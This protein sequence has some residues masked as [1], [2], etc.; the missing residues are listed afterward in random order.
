MKTDLQIAR[1][2]KIQPV[3]KIAKALGI[4]EGEYEL[5]GNFMAKLDLAVRDRL[6]KRPNGKYI[7]ITA[8]TPTPL[9]EGKTTTTIGLGMALNLLGKQAI[10]AIRQPSMGPTFGIKGG[11]AGGGYAQVIPMEQFNLHLT[12]DIHA[13]SAAHNLIAAMLDNH[14]AKG[15]ALKIDLA[16]IT[17]PRVVDISDRSLRKITI[18]DNNG[19]AE[20]GVERKTK[21]DIAVAS[22]LMAILA[23]ASD[24]SDLR[25]RIAKI[26]LAYDTKGTPIT[27]E[28]IKAAGAAT[29]L[30]KEAIKPTLVQ[31]LTNT[32]AIVHAGPFANIAHGNSSIIADQIGLKLA[33]YLVTESGFGADIG[34]E[35]FMDIKCRYSGLTPDAVV[36]VATVRGIKY[37]SGKFEVIP[38]KPLPADLTK[39]D[40]PSLAKGVVNLEKQ[41]ENAR[42]FGIPVVVAVNRFSTDT[43]KEIKYLITESRKVGAFAA[44]ESTVFKDG[45]KGGLALANAVVK[46]TKQKTHFSF[47]YP[48]ERPLKE[49]IKTIATKIYGA[50]DVLYSDLAEKQV[51]I[52]EQNSLG[53]LP[54]CMAKTHLSL[55]D[56][57]KKVGRP[58][59]F[60]ITVKELKV[61]AGAGFIYPLLGEMRT[62]PGLPTCPNAEK[63]DIDENGQIVGLS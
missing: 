57:P 13:I 61:A 44:V 37:H 24:L 2:A 53:A 25:S 28:A 39:E 46:A 55:S 34:M 30:L 63:I 8:I 26:V 15:N 60:S 51:K 17:W 19:V 12:G 41:I 5:Y 20:F 54:I 56:D 23:L 32:P 35:K 36:M 6:S 29:V 14:I 33:D 45:A 10:V 3:S 7:D 11:A 21:F 9:G 16:T 31:T 38:G 49:K 58:K 18:G 52:I 59:G 62:M 22:E 1:E 47:L 27:A 42:L 4:N 48:L 43:D 50:K 40:L